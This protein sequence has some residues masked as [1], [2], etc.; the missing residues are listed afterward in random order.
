MGFASKYDQGNGVPQDHLK[1]AN[2]YR[3]ACDGE[4]MT[5]CSNLGTLTYWGRGVAENKSKGLALLKQGCDGG[6]Q[7]GCD[8]LKELTE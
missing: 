8:R 5:A 4:N 2:L 1:A 3:Q 7:F 6:N